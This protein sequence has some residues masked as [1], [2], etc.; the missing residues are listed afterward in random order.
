MSA[1]IFDKPMLHAV[2]VSW[3][4][5]EQG[6]GYRPDGVS[7]HISSQSAKDYIVEYWKGMPKEVPYEYTRNDDQGKSVGVTPELYHRIRESKGSILRLGPGEYY[8]L[9]ENGSIIR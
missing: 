4:E 1:K 7:L 6:W 2:M 5:S 8:Q 9:V 3:T